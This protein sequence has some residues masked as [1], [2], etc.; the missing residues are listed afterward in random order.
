MNK[1]FFYG[2]ELV[3][4]Q[5]DGSLQARVRR[6]LQE[7]H[8]ALGSSLPAG[9]TASQGQAG[10]QTPGTPDDETVELLRMIKSSSDKLLNKFGPM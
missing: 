10:A 1:E 7:A 5:V 4:L 2:S 6:A 3:F 9:Y 8:D